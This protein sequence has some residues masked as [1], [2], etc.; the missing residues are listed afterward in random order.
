[1]S[2]GNTRDAKALL[3]MSENSC[4]KRKDTLFPFLHAVKSN[5]SHLVQSSDSHLLEIPV[6]AY[7][8]HM[9]T[10]TVSGWGKVMWWSCDSCCHGD[11]LTLCAFQSVEWRNPKT[12]ESENWTS[13]V[14]PKHT[15]PLYVQSSCNNTVINVPSVW[16]VKLL[17][18]QENWSL[19]LQAIILARLSL[20]SINVAITMNCVFV[21]LLVFSQ[22]SPLSWYRGH[23]S[24]AGGE[25]HSV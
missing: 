1:M 24:Q 18:S 2:G 25:R 10:V 19:V 11:T 3:K 16:I 14:V 23:Q 20:S 6:W 5:C 7:D 21:C 17:F 8:G 12:W 13:F 15:S 22:R 4:T 9:G